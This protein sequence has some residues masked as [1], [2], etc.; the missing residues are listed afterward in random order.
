MSSID[1][2]EDASQQPSPTEKSLSPVSQ[3]L[4]RYKKM[5]KVG[6]GTYGVV[7]KVSTMSI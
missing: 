3:K 2:Y 1:C 7:Y 4:L 5:E 6:E